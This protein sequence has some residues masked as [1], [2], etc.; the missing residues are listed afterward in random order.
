VKALVVRLRL[1]LPQA[2]NYLRRLAAHCGELGPGRFTSQLSET[3]GDTGLTGRSRPC[4]TD[5]TRETEDA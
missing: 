5:S 1:G 3:T 4:S 2:V